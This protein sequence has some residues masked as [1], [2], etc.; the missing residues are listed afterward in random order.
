VIKATDEGV[1][2]DHDWKGSIAQIN[3]NIKKQ[4]A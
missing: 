1:Q 2:Y 4:M 3:N